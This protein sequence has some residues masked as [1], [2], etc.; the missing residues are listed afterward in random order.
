MNLKST[1]LT[2]FNVWADQAEK[3]APLGS[4]QA[5]EA[6]NNTVC[7]KAPKAQHYSSSESNDFRVACVV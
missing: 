7:S 1:L 6:A 2:E 4:S 5:N 3:L